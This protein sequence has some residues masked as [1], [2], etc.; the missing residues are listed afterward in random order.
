MRFFFFVLSCRLRRG[1]IL[2]DIFISPGDNSKAI[3]RRGHR[4]PKA[5][6][7]TLPNGRI[8]AYAFLPLLLRKG[9]CK[10]FLMRLVCSPCLFLLLTSFVTSTTSA[11]SRSLRRRNTRH[12]SRRSPSLAVSPY[13]STLDAVPSHRWIGKYHPYGMTWRELIGIFSL[14]LPHS[15]RQS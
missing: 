6:V 4:M 5:R 3:Y 1:D 14:S 9:V 2:G 7:S 15:A 8:P 12:S 11:G 13:A 10:L